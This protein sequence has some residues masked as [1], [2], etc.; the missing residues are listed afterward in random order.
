M[1]DFSGRRSVDLGAQETAGS[2]LSVIWKRFG[3]VLGEIIITEYGVSVD[4]VGKS[5]S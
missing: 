2:D 3:C 1:P 5:F 4:N